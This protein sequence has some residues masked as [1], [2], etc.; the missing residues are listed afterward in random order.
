MLPVLGWELNKYIL[1]DRS[2]VNQNLSDS[3][4]FDKFF[5]QLSTKVTAKKPLVCHGLHPHISYE[6]VLKG[7]C[8][9]WY[10]GSRTQHAASAHMSPFHLSSVPWVPGSAHSFLVTHKLY[11][12]QLATY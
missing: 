7:I 11:L 12:V 10:S 5:H 8:I 2:S 1:Y 9:D 6:Q 3:S 4:G